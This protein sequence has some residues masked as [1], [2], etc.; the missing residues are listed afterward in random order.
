MKRTLLQ[1]LFLWL[2]LVTVSVSCSSSL[3]PEGKNSVRATT[4]PQVSGE[5]QTGYDVLWQEG[6]EISIGGKIFRLHSGAGTSDAVFRIVSDEMPADGKYVAYFPASYNG[7]SW[8]N[9]Q[10]YAGDKIVGAPMTAEAVVSGANVS[11]LHFNNAGGVLRITVKGPS[12]IRVKSVEVTAGELEGAITLTCGSPVE[13]N[14]ESGVQF[15]IALPPS[16]SGYSS[17]SISF[18]DSSGFLID[19]ESLEDR[20]IVVGRASVTALSF[21]IRR[22]TGLRVATFNVDGLPVYVSLGSVLG[23]FVRSL[24]IPDRRI[25]DDNNIY[26]NE[27]GPGARGS[28]ELGKAI[29][30]KD[31]DVFGLNED[32]NYHNEIWA[33][34]ERY[35]RGTYLGAFEASGLE[36]LALVARVAAQQPL[37]EIDGLE[38][39]VRSDFFSIDAE[40]IVPWNS[41]A[42]YGYFTNDS[43]E[44]TKKGFRYYSVAVNKD[45][46][47]T[48]VDF[49]IMHADAGSAPEDKKAREN[50]YTQIL[51]FIKGLYSTAPMILMGDWN[52][53]YFRDN[54]KALFIDKLNE[55]QGI[56]VSDAWVECHN[57]GIYP[58]YGS[59]S[60]EKAE[61]KLD[62][63][64]FLNRDNSPVALEPVSMDY[65]PGIVDADGKQISD[66][67]PAEAE[68]RILVK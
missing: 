56:S 16:D 13:L 2:T 37:F 27:D 6:D 64:L 19:R 8:V 61:D 12:D 3:D 9:A 23:A 43:D 62:K 14:P 10:T 4:E 35:Y 22:N 24:N 67:R 28:R 48:R 52:T 54:F 7:V 20:R 15:N 17:V 66:H 53:R 18:K 41:D 32:F 42:V 26:I 60:A 38:F 55:I 31:W 5:G 58:E 1:H 11:E 34:L 51:N 39:G 33:S 45:G 63:I 44:L 50:G 29:S 49:I 65:L 46:I 47:S 40:R 25:D 30:G 68:F 36:Y 59:A 57:G 21:D